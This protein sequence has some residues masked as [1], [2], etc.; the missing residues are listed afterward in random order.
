MSLRKQDIIQIYRKRAKRYDVTANLYYLIGSRPRKYRKMAVDALGLCPGDTV[1]EIG[2][3]TGLN[4]GFLEKPVGPRGK[5]IGLDL[6]DAMLERAR[7]RVK[8]KCWDNVELIRT[9]AAEYSFPDAV[10]GILSF[11]AMCLIPEYDRVIFNGANALLPGRQFVILE[12]RPLQKPIWLQKLF[13]LITRP[14]GASPDDF[15]QCPWE[16]IERYLRNFSYRKL[17]FGLVYLARGEA[18]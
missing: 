13:L 16:S 11:F 2:C 14:F 6:T 4:F 8:K 12:P 1:V 7:K 15:N 5:I 10:D 3:G 9:D 17:F 18:V